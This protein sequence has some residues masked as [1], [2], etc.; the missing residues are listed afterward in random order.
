MCECDLFLYTRFCVSIVNFKVY[1][2]IKRKLSR[3]LI[4]C[5]YKSNSFN[6]IVPDNTIFDSMYLRLLVCVR[7]M[8]G[9]HHYFCI[10]KAYLLISMF[11][12]YKWMKNC[13]MHTRVCPF[14]M[15]KWYVFLLNKHRV[16]VNIYVS[17]KS[18]S[19]PGKRSE[20]TDIWASK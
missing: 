15:I 14:T 19:G 4:L 2:Y 6:E 12:P 13:V 3:V 5:T 9:K 17:W 11:T 1:T 10:V 16:Q 7:E 18:K 8:E 20:L